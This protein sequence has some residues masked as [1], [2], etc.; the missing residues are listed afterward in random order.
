MSDEKQGAR[1]GHDIDGQPPGM[2]RWVKITAV[3]V[4][5]LV[6]LFLVL[7]LTGVAGQHGP[8]RHLSDGR[9]PVAVSTTAVVS[10]LP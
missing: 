9:A 2:P 1:R 8:G 7:Q 6:L 5:V 3:V 10:A 4:G